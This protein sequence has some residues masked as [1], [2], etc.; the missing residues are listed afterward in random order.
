MA[1]YNIGFGMDLTSQA[2]GIVGS[3]LTEHPSWF[4]TRFFK[5]GFFEAQERVRL[6][7]QKS[8]PWTDEVAEQ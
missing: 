5:P 4:P 3:A 8:A 2:G 6:F 1:S 7:L